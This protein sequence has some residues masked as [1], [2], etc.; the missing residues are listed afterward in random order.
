MASDYQLDYNGTI[1]GDGTTWDVVSWGG[2]EEFTTRNT[3]VTIPAGW[4]SISG[5]SFVDPRVVTITIESID[6]AAIALLEQVLV[7]PALSAPS[8]LV[9]IRWKFPNREEL[10]AQARCARRGRPRDLT[11]ALGKTSLTF[12]L[13]I[14][15]PRQYAYAPTAYVG[16]VFVAGGGGWEL[17]Q[18]SGTNLGWDLNVGATVDLGWELSVGATGSGLIAVVNS[19][20]VETYGVFTFNA[21]TGLSQWSVTNTTTGVVASFLTALSS[22]QVLTADMKAA[23]TSSGTT[24]PITIGGVARY[25]AWVAPRT[26]M[27]FPPGT[28]LL[29]FDIQSGDQLATFALSAASAYL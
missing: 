12:E 20:S 27:A 7:P 16:S 6:P 14:P 25:S 11:T 10:T 24:A 5:S 2:L 21:G 4:G 29:R 23:A 15:D 18:S 13:E 28:S 22:G 9:A 8:S 17:N 3:D 1:I 26:A 19:G